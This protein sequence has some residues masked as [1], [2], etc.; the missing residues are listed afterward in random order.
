[1][2]KFANILYKYQNCIDT[3]VFIYSRIPKTLVIGQ[4]TEDL[5]K[6]DGPFDTFYHKLT[7]LIIHKKIKPSVVISFEEEPMEIM[8]IR[9][10]QRF[11]DAFLKKNKIYEWYIVDPSKSLELVFTFVV[12]V[13]WQEYEYPS[14][15]KYDDFLWLKFFS[16]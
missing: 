15:D 8:S 6:S 5:F 7:H 9:V 1:M 2:T 13:E 11:W 16:K 3:Q 12:S 4:E 10:L 14:F